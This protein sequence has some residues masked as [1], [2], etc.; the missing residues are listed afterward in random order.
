MLVNLG[1]LVLTPQIKR[2]EVFGEATLAIQQR[3]CRQTMDMRG[4][5]IEINVNYRSDSD[6]DVALGAHEFVALALGE[7]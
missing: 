5:I 4:P 6:R 2:V 1:R 3:R 7:L